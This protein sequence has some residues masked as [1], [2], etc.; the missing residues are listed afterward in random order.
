MYPNSKWELYQSEQSQYIYQEMYL[1]NYDLA[2]SHQVTDN[3]EF[4]LEKLEK[5]GVAKFQTGFVSNLEV[6]IATCLCAID[7]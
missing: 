7:I 2:S 4:I 3:K 5:W 1:N 6:S